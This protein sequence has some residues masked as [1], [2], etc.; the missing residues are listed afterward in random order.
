M[1]KTIMFIMALANLLHGY[2][3]VEDYRNGY[4]QKVTHTKPKRHTE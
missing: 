1:K 4:I 3:I 2:E